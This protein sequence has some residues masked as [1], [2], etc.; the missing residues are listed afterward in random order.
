MPE[1]ANTDAQRLLH[2]DLVSAD[3]QTAIDVAAANGAWGWKVNGAGAEG[4]S[5]TLLCGP[6]MRRKRR[7]LAALHEVPVTDALHASVHDRV[8]RLRFSD[9]STIG[10]FSH[11][12]QRWQNAVHSARRAQCHFA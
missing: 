8:Q 5:L 1:T 7:L 10:R 9:I 3:A 6:D 11:G 4:G 12:S 2:P